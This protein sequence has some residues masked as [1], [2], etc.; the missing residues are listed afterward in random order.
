MPLMIN[1]C[2]LY[3]NPVMAMSS[4]V[5]A[6]I[7]SRFRAHKKRSCSRSANDRMSPL[8]RFFPSDW[9]LS[10]SSLSLAISV[11]FLSM[12]LSYPALI[13]QTLAFTPISKAIR[14]PKMTQRALSRT[15][16]WSVSAL[17]ALFRLIKIYCLSN[18]HPS[19]YS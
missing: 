11:S 1:F 2:L 16:A 18:A 15:L 6:P 7:F 5:S 10:I 3:L 17:S 19:T 9:S 12:I 14:M 13:I 8:E 4:G